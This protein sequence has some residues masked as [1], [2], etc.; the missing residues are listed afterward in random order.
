[1]YSA[2]YCNNTTSHRK[3]VPITITSLSQPPASNGPTASRVFR[4][5]N[6]PAYISYL[7]ICRSISRP[8]KSLPF[9][10]PDRRGIAGS[11]LCRLRQETTA[12][13]IADR[14]W[15]AVTTG[16]NNQWTPPPKEMFIHIAYEFLWLYICSLVT[17]FNLNVI[18]KRKKN[19]ILKFGRIKCENSQFKQLDEWRTGDGIGPNPAINWLALLWTS[20]RL[21]FLDSSSGHQKPYPPDLRREKAQVSE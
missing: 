14:W 3:H 12:A 5:Q 1:M 9:T 7:I 6:S 21:L 18:K 4:D 10:S 2:T 13:T 11:C 16:E 15:C 17:T 8:D 19:D 20:D